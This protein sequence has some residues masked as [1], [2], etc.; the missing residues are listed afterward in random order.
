MVR[1][2]YVDHDTVLRPTAQ[3]EVDVRI[4]RKGIDEPRF[5]G[6]LEP[7]T[8]TS[9]SRVYAS[10]SFLPA[11]FSDIRVPV[12]NASEQSQILE[13]GTELGVVESV[14]LIDSNSTIADD[15][16]EN[17]QQH[18]LTEPEAE[19]IAKMIASFPS[20]LSDEQQAKVEA[21]LI[22]HRKILSTGDHDIGRTHLLEHRIDM[23]DA[24]PIRQPL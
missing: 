1:R 10:R 11:K 9:L 19:V 18:D 7:E 16:R 24:R 6:L 21:L 13:R 3:T 14:E 8:I 22:R 4:S 15:V 2:C 5:E 20:E 12:L 23:G 17:R